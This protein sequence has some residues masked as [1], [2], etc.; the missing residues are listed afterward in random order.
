MNSEIEDEHDQRNR[1][2]A[3]LQQGRELF[4]LSPNAEGRKQ[5]LMM[6][7]QALM[8]LRNIIK[9]LFF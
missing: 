8:L 6:T 9:G 2:L 4:D 1:V 5:A 7:V 3:L